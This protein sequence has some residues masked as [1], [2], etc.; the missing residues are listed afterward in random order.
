MCGVTLINYRNIMADVEIYRISFE[1]Q[2]DRK[3]FVNF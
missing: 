1:G 3:S 2:I